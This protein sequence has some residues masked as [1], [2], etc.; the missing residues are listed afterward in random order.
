MA[1]GVGL[2]TGRG[3]GT[4]TTAGGGGSSEARGATGGALASGVTAQEAS[5]NAPSKPATLAGRHICT[6][7]VVAA[8]VTQLKL[9]QL[10]DQD[11]L[12]LTP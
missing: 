3:G 2:R 1:G 12:P 10:I 11:R 5:H 4:R 8:I 7:P 6:R 9:W